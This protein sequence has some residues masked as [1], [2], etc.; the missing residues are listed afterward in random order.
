M[1]E[2]PIQLHQNQNEELLSSQDNCAINSIDNASSITES[3]IQSLPEVNTIIKENPS[4]TINNPINLPNT[5]LNETEDD[6]NSDNDPA[7]NETNTQ[8]INEMLAQL[9]TEQEDPTK[10][11]STRLVNPTR[12]KQDPLSENL[13]QKKET[14]KLLTTFN[15]E[16]PV[17]EIEGTTITYT[18]NKDVQYM[19]INLIASKLLQG[20][21]SS[22]SSTY[23]NISKRNFIT[24]LSYQKPC[25]LSDDAFFDVL[26]YVY[27]NIDKQS[28]LQLLNEYVVNHF[29][30]ELQGNTALLNRVCEFYK[31]NDVNERIKFY[32]HELTIGELVS[33]IQD[34][35]D[36]RTYTLFM[37][38]SGQKV[39]ATNDSDKEQVELPLD[40]STS[41][42]EITKWSSHEIAKQLTLITC[43][44][45]RN[46]NAKEVLNCLW[47]KAD[48]MKTSPNITKLIN[49]FNQISCWMSDEILSYDHASQRGKIIAK[50]IEIADE[51]Q[52]MKNYN[53]CFNIVTAFNYLPIKRLTKSWNRVGET[54]LETLKK[55]SNLCSLTRNWGNLREEY[56]KYKE[57][58]ETSD[59]IG[60]I[61]YVGYFLKELAFIDEGPKYF[62]DNDL[63]CV[64]KIVKVGKV[65]DELKYFQKMGYNYQ[66]AFALSV[67][68]EPKPQDEDKLLALSKK[69]EPKFI[70][71]KSKTMKKRITETDQKYGYFNIGGNAFS[72]V[73]S[74]N[75]INNNNSNSGSGGNKNNQSVFNGVFKSFLKENANVN[76]KVMTLR[77]RLQLRNLLI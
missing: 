73:L 45:F 4:T 11:D 39:Y 50:F 75:V 47:T 42:F 16:L 51:L 24:Y 59:K 66:P 23:I 21:L 53:D 9:Q 40:K 10:S 44:L 34:K 68:A 48:K 12:V 8:A 18:S 41:Y 38:W 72:N 62:N 22:S 30:G 35:D 69:L 1:D 56:K 5:Q 25:L 43:H 70:L 54:A 49:R 13:P 77:E 60:C 7:E 20:A 71:L 33:T 46:I 27:A 19:S 63:I 31:R 74:S 29:K 2:L 6:K 61:P 17:D 26:S 36:I 55:L 52:K 58:K 32:N 28:A 3:N 57:I 64:E 65:I 76:S 14:K 37:E 15:T 67:L